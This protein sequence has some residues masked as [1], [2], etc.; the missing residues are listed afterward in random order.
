M[1]IKNLGSVLLVVFL[2]G[3]SPNLGTKPLPTGIPGATSGVT[4]QAGSSPQPPT[5]TPSPVP[6]GETP[7]PT[8]IPT[9]SPTIIPLTP[10]PVGSIEEQCG[11]VLDSLPE[12]TRLPARIVLGSPALLN[13]EL[14]D[15]YI[16]RLEYWDPNSN[17]K[18]SLLKGKELVDGGEGLNIAPDFNHLDYLQVE[19]QAGVDQYKIVV[20]NNIG[21]RQAALP[22]E[23]RWS[24]R[25]NWWDSETLVIR[26]GGS[27]GNEQDKDELRYPLLLLNP[28]TG[29]RKQLPSI[30]EDM[31]DFMGGRIPFL[32]GIGFLTNDPGLQYRTYLASGEVVFE[33]LQ[34]HQTITRLPNAKNFLSAVRW[35][36]NGKQFIVTANWPPDPEKRHSELV[37]I[38]LD[39]QIR[40][41]TQLS[42]QY[43]DVSMPYYAWSPD[44]SKIALW[45]S[46]DG[47]NPYHVRL[48]ILDVKTLQLRLTCTESIYWPFSY[49]GIFWSP[50]GQYL[51][52]G[53]AY[54]PGYHPTQIMVMNA[55]EGWSVN[56][57]Q[58]QY[59]FGWIMGPQQ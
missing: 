29:Q 42:S 6:P 59:V 44:G 33:D 55:V 39:G 19:N 20:V 50:D 35:S 21:K 53:I 32:Q 48:A 41:L 14:D 57:A 37:Q 49:G 27:G 8:S 46:T 13:G 3:C 31:Y 17:E 34:T 45:I 43:S 11:P 28:F 40:P 5:L 54:H 47:E 51:L 10:T 23:P 15:Y 52:Y 16:D 4:A 36:P 1:K 12:G 26:S 56:V 7:S 38:G 2:L 9:Q 25:T 58:D 22:L 30:P 18:K 24:G